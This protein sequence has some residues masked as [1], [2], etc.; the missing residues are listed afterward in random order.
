LYWGTAK[1][2]SADRMNNG[3]KTI[4]EKMVEKYGYEEAC[5]INAKGKTGNTHGSGNKGKPKSEEH[6]R[7][8]A[9]NR[10]GG[11]QKLVTE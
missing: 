10:K 5:K 4:W 3:D 9:A 11:R 2:N 8:I 7:K 1:E 6:K